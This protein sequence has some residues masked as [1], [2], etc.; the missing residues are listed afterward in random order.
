LPPTVIAVP[1][2]IPVASPEM[3]RNMMFALNRLSLALLH[4]LDLMPVVTDQ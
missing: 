2:T 3:N 1:S 4:N